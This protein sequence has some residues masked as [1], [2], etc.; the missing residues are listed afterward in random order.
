MKK[1]LYHL[2][3]MLGIG[4]YCVVGRRN[5]FVDKLNALTN[6]NFQF[7]IKE[8]TTRMF[9]IVSLTGLKLEIEYH[10][11]DKGTVVNDIVVNE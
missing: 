7:V 3:G 9:K 8:D 1:F 10:M 11:N 5:A 6:D 4:K 2:M